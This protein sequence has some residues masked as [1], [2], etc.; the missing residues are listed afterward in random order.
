MDVNK[1]NEA[2]YL[3]ITTFASDHVFSKGCSFGSTDEYNFMSQNS[4]TTAGLMKPA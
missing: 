2:K 1:L 3:K 4:C